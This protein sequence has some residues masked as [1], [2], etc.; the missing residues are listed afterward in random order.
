MSK[1]LQ[2]YKLDRG[3]GEG[4]GSIIMLSTMRAVL[5]LMVGLGGG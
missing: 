4:V 5:G 1:M 3:E 2:G